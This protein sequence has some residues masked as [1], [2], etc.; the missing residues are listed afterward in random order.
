M[1]RI[2]VAVL[3]VFLAA[4]AAAGACA[5]DGGAKPVL[6]PKCAGL[7]KSADCWRKFANKSGC[8][9][10]TDNFRP[11]STITWSGACS[12]GVGV[13]PGTM[14]W[15]LDS[16]SG[17]GTGTLDRGRMH[18]RW[19]M[20]F[21]DGIVIEGPFENNRRHGH[22]VF[23]FPSGTVEE[24]PYVKG[25]KQGRWIT[26]FASGSVLEGPLVGGMRHGRWVH[27]FP[28]GGRLEYEYRYGSFEGQPGLYV[29]A[30]GQSASG[31]WS[32]FC[33][34]DRNGVLRV[35]HGRKTVEQCREEKHGADTGRSTN[36]LEKNENKD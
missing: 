33:F 31:T 16:E 26:R 5:Q 18:G 4:T 1:V 15:T 29:N 3:A 2:G 14:R 32:G 30:R 24:G 21:W 17:E 10:L 7:W 34:W 36:S 20:R 27:R 35:T 12:G 22:W 28:S 8:H 6:S 9:Y 23:R 25:R 19:V 13:G 11:G